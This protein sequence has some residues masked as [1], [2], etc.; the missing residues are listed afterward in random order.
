MTS[1]GGFTF[2]GKNSYFNQGAIHTRF[3]M[4]AMLD[5]GDI[6]R[7]VYMIGKNPSII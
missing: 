4:V 5:T 6:A 3:V 7:W 1:Q 2:I